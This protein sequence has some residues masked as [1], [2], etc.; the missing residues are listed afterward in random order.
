MNEA[1]TGVLF[2]FQDREPIFYDDTNALISYSLSLGEGEAKEYDNLN[3][4]SWYFPQFYSV[5]GSLSTH[6]LSEVVVYN[7]SHDPIIIQERNVFYA[8]KHNKYSL[9]LQLLLGKGKK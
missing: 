2:K 3:I 8:R 6:L 9:N 1:L 5:V 7:I 4:L